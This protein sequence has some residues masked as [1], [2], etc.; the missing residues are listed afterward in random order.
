MISYEIITD[1]EDINVLLGKESTFAN[2]HYKYSQETVDMLKKYFLRTDS[3]YLIVKDEGVFVAFCSL[4][5][6][7]WEPQYFFLREIFVMPEYQG[8]QIGMELIQR[9]IQHSQDNGAIGVVT[10]TAFENVP[11]QK[12][13]EKC[14]FQ[15]WDNPE[16]KEGVTYKLKLMDK[17]S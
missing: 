15:K 16:W 5:S 12:L 7:W 8:Q 13:C 14:G 11:M 10:E 17:N 1:I 9:S 6:D 2:L 3:F 4:D